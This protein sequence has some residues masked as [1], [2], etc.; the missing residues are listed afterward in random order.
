RSL[1][2]SSDA[3]R[4]YVRSLRY[5]WIELGDTLE[6]A[7]TEGI[8]PEETILQFIRMVSEQEESNTDAHR[9]ISASI[10]KTLDLA[11]GRLPFLDQVATP[12]LESFDL[13]YD[14]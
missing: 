11:R 12:F 8:L 4:S 5:H 9:R 1:D 13:S 10:K 3:I 2:R 6:Q 14:E 7:R